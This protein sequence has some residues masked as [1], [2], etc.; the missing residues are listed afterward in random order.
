MGDPTPRV[1]R[2]LAQRPLVVLSGAYLGLSTAGYLL[3]QQAGSSAGLWFPPAGLA[4]GYLL[5]AGLR[6][7]PV[8]I[9]AT[10][11]GAVLTPG[12]SPV[13]LTGDASIP[14]AGLI[15]VPTGLAFASAVALALWFGLAAVAQRGLWRADASY[16]SLAWFVVFGVTL[17]PLGA[18]T[19]IATTVVLTGQPFDSALWAKVVI[20][21]ATATVTLAPATVLVVERA[22][23]GRR[24][25]PQVDVRRRIVLVTQATVIVLTPAVFLVADA[26]H[27]PDLALMAVP[28]APLLWMVLSPDQTRGAVVLAAAGLAVG[29]VAHLPDAD[30]ATTFRLQ[31]V[32]FAGAVATLFAGVALAADHRATRLASLQS[33]RWRALIEASPAMVARVRPDGRWVAE[34]RISGS[35]R[36]DPEAMHLAARA[37]AVPALVEATRDGT[38]HTIQW[39]LDDDTGRRFVTH[40]TPLP[41]G[42]SL[43]VTTE[44]TRLHSAEIT[45]AW[46]RSHD[47]ETDLPNRDLLVATAEQA[48]RDATASS[49]VLVDLERLGRLALVNADPVRLLLVLAERLRDLLPATE[50]ASGHAL[51]ARTGDHQFGVLVPGEAEAARLLATRMVDALQ[52]PVPTPPTP[53]TVTA[54]AGVAPLAAGRSAAESLRRAGAAVQAAIEARQRSVVVAD[55]IS[56]STTAER[57]RLA[58]EVLGAVQRGELEVVF[59]PDVRLPD[60][61]LTGVEALVRWRRRDGY[62]T[63][64]EVF[65]ELAEEVGAVQAV[66]GWVMEESLREVGTWRRDHNALD[67]EI[68]LNVSALS[69]TEDL[70]DRLFD[71]CL[72]HDVPPRNVR[73]EVT[74]TALADD[75]SAPSVLRRV[76]ARGCRVALDDFGTRYATLSRLNR[77]PVDVVKLDRSFLPPITQSAGSQALVRL[78]LGLAGPL[79]VEVVVEGVE[80]EEQRDLLIDL[81]CR[82]AQGFLFSRPVTAAVIR[83]ML[84][85]GTPLGVPQDVTVVDLVTPGAQTGPTSTSQPGSPV[86]R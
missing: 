55:G 16:G 59:Q 52:Q 66:D 67:L 82:R 21:T 73:L 68:A 46:E 74:E 1:S 50:L 15:G 41:D 18:A 2:S 70:P 83:G 79:R 17:S 29:A 8:V 27:G 30:P 36:P 62:V 71:A 69:L 13:P 75:S 24:L 47:R 25:K 9:V 54:W 72:R 85:A 12:G 77:F 49:L 35:G 32:M 3:S 4:F 7:I 63:T 78:V 65:V 84:D 60:G 20:G 37:A 6:G 53:L 19:I 34:P 58:G 22:V 14:G 43:A 23:T 64:T 31:A 57:A 39:G 42:G 86:P 51:I 33:T 56:F 40:L 5:V 76:R 28:L 11:A 10:G 61:R 44:T 80:T 26:A 45:L 48:A 81:G 38:A